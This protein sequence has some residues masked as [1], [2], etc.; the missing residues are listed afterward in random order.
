MLFTRYL[1]ASSEIAVTRQEERI[2]SRD[3]FLFP[4]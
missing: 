2:K 4:L 3:S 1:R